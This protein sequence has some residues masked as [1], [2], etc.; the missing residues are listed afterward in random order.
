MLDLSCLEEVLEAFL[1]DI[2]PECQ[3]MHLSACAFYGTMAFITPQTMKVQGIIQGQQLTILLDSGNTHNFVD[4][5]LLKRYG[6]FCSPTK[7]FEVMIADV[8]RVNS[9]RCCRGIPLSMGE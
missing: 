3:S 8:G 1:G 6:W 4:S 7:Q 9:S 2:S 5:R